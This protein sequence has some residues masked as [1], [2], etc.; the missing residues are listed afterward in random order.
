M[1]KRFAFTL[2]E[3]IFAIVIIAITVMSLPMMSQ[4]TSKGIESNIVQEAIFAGAAELNQVV[5]YRW[6]ENSTDGTTFLTRVINSAANDCNSTTNLRVGHINQPKHRVCL[7]NLT[8]RPTA[9]ANFGLDAGELVVADYDDIDDKHGIST[10]IFIGGAP[11][12]ASGY[13]SDYKKSISVTY[14][15][16]DPAIDNGTNIKKIEATITDANG[17]RIVLLRTYSANIGEID[18]HKRTY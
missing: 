4:I 13:K 16:F 6:D 14:A 10:S 9:A 17:N 5:S 2:I 7:N 1:V 8:I 15:R 18:Y 3:L 11:A 12:T